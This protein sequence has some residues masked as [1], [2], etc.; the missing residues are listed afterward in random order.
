MP[1]SRTSQHP[2]L[3]FLPS[4][5]RRLIVWLAVA[6]AS[7]LVVLVFWE[8]VIPWKIRV[9]IEEWWCRLHSVPNHSVTLSLACEM[10]RDFNRLPRERWLDHLL[11]IP[12]PL[13]FFHSPHDGPG[14]QSDPALHAGRKGL[15]PVPPPDGNGSQ[16]F[17]QDS[18]TLS[19]A[20]RAAQQCGGTPPLPGSWCGMAAV[21]DPGRKNLAL[22]LHREWFHPALHLRHRNRV[23][24]LPTTVPVINDWLSRYDRLREEIDLFPFSPFP[25]DP[26]APDF[27]T[28][29]ETDGFFAAPRLATC[30]C[31]TDVDCLPGSVCHVSIPAPPSDTFT[32]CHLLG[33]IIPCQ[34]KCLPS[35]KMPAPPVQSS[36]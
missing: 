17:C 9:H 16:P 28:H 36:S 27:A 1:I 3:R 22:V 24:I 15:H 23:W 7:L 31:A 26:A 4:R 8:W 32:C 20:G 30:D 25:G 13:R 6:G 33:V 12:P 29:Y 34:G 35:E 14:D 19:P 10:A 5:F 21:P 18:R 2:I 11:S